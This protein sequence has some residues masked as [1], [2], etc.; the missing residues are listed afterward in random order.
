MSQ[1]I[2][3]LSVFIIREEGKRNI[4]TSEIKVEW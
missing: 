3:L 4:N 2:N 1:I